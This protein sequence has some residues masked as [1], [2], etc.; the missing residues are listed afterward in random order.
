MA[1]VSPVRGTQSFLRVI[2]ACWRRPSL[3]ATELGWHWLAGIP[4]LAI[5]L[6]QLWR[7]YAAAGPVLQPLMNLS[8]ETITAD[9]E[10]AGALFGVASAAIRPALIHAAIGLGPAILFAWAV[11]SG[12]GRMAVL[13]RY[14]PRLAR[15]PWT[16][17]FFNLAASATLA[18]MVAVWFVALDWSAKYALGSGELNLILY[19]ALVI[20]ISLGMFFLRSLVSWVWL[21]APVVAVVEGISGAEAIALSLRVRRVRGKLIEVNLVMG[22][23]KLALIV[24]ATVFSAIPLPFSADMQGPPLWAWWAFVSVLYLAASDFFKM[25]RVIAFVEFWRT[26][27]TAEAAQ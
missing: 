3:L 26:E 13:A 24:L 5:V 17:A 20:S 8:P 6:Y 15:R 18:A 12:F 16:F 10:Q 9:P 22:I 23:I 19:A 7:I 14:D 4:A 2:G 1:A 21:A 11:C 25:A 27:R